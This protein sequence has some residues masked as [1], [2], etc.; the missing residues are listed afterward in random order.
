MYVASF[1]ETLAQIFVVIWIV[2]A[3]SELTTILV[4]FPA[5]FLVAI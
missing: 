1:D 3:Q 4:F 2:K 5:K